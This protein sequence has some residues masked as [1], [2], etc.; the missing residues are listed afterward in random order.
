MLFLLDN[1]EK[2]P[3]FKE[4]LPTFWPS[5]VLASAETVPYLGPKDVF[6]KSNVLL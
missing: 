4:P 6:Q 5:S 2:F 3:L 1:N